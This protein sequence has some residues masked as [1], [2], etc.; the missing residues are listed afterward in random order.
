MGII[1]VLPPQLLSCN[2]PTMTG[3]VCVFILFIIQLCMPAAIHEEY[4]E[5]EIMERLPTAYLRTATGRVIKG[6]DCEYIKIGSIT[7]NTGCTDGNKFVIKQVSGVRKQFLILNGEAILGFVTKGKKFAGCSSYTEITANVDCKVVSGLID[8]DLTSSDN[9]ATAAAADTTTAAAAA[10]TTTSAAAYTTVA[11][12]DTTTA[13]AAAD[14]TTAAADTTD[15]AS[16]TT[17]A[18][19]DTTAAAADTTA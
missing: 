4:E 17:A 14:T 10:D 2:Y 19:A 9:A 16:D 13:A 7:A 1:I 5:V 3:P 8:V 15:A 18:A 12:A 11:A 6:S